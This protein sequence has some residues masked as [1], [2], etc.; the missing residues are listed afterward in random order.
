MPCPTCHAPNAW[1]YGTSNQGRTRRWKCK[2]CGKVFTDNPRGRPKRVQVGRCE[3]GLLVS[4][5]DGHRNW[6][7]Y[8]RQM[9]A[10]RF[11]LRVE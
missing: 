8:A 7:Q 3:C 6:I 2:L 10:A 4:E 1:K 5:C 9:G 11:R